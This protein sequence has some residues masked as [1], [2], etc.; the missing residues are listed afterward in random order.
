MTGKQRAHRT[1]SNE[2]GFVNWKTRSSAIDR[3][4]GML[5]NSSIGASAICT[6]AVKGEWHER[7]RTTARIF[8]RICLGSL[9]N[10]CLVSGLRESTLVQVPSRAG[11]CGQENFSSTP[12]NPPVPSFFTPAR[13]R[14]GVHHTRCEQPA[15]PPGRLISLDARVLKQSGYGAAEAVRRRR[16]SINEPIASPPSATTGM[17]KRALRIVPPDCRSDGKSTAAGNLNHLSRPHG[18]CLAGW[19]AARNRRWEESSS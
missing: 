13:T 15:S 11:A 4:L 9:S 19:R 5:S 7:S 6:V 8:A 16:S 3:H 1:G 17:T 14:T 12:D 18:S 10:K 2:L